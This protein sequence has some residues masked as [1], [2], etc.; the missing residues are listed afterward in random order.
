MEK[1][2]SIPASVAQQFLRYNLISSFGRGTLHFL[3]ATGAIGILFL[4]VMLA[5]WRSPQR[6]RTLVLQ[7]YAIGFQSLPVVVL[8]G[9]AIGMVLGVQLLVTLQAFKGES[10]TG[11][12]VNFAL[13]S[14]LGPTLTGLMLAGRVGSSIAAE[15]GTMKVTEQID[16]LRT[17]G[18]DPIAYLVV[19]RFLACVALL[20]FLTAIACFAGVFGSGWLLT[21]GYGLPSASYW[22]R[23]LDF[24]SW[25]EIVTGLIKTCVFGGIIALV[26]CRAG[27]NTR[28]G[29][30]GVGRSCTEGV[31]SAS[32]LILLSNFVMTLLFQVAASWVFSP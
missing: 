1:H 25:W 13:F 9:L 18:T 5:L 28:G 11:A 31:V 24:N 29:A 26:A 3:H 12:M 27:L 30:T 7:M 2:R 19:P 22:Q 23:A 17:M 14:Q 15:L 16:A 4:Q 6:R 20:P 10:M 32:I 8:T 21:Y